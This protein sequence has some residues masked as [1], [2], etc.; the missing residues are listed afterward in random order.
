MERLDLG[1]HH[2]GRDV[3]RDS[4]E[5]DTLVLIEVLT[6]RFKGMIVCDGWKPYAKFTNPIQRC[7][8]HLL[9]ESKDLAE[10]IAEAVP[11]HE[12]TRGDSMKN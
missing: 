7:W 11:L 9:R 5:R 12:N 4:E 1:I 3:C 10:K 6:R 8:A 2:T